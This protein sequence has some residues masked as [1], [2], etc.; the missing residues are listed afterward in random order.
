[1]AV[2]DKLTGAAAQV[3]QVSKEV[4]DYQQALKDLATHRRNPTVRG[5]LLA[6]ERKLATQISKNPKMLE[7]ARELGVDKQVRASAAIAERQAQSLSQGVT[8]NVSRGRGV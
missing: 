2:S 8:H 1:M 7:Q 6:T 4:L 3:P 5:E